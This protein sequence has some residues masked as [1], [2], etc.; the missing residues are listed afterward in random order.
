MT[1]PAETPDDRPAAAGL[2]A[3]LI[4]VA[5]HTLVFVSLAWLVRVEYAQ[6]P[7]EPE[8]SAGIALVRQADGQMEFFHGDGEQAAPDAAQP[9][10][11]LAADLP[12]RD[13]LASDIEGALPSE[14][15]L[16]GQGAG[17]SAL[18]SA[19][20]LTRGGG[21]SRQVQG[22]QAQ[23]S[24]FGAQGTGTRFLYVFDRSGSMEGYG[25]RPLRASKRELVQSLGDL[26]ETHQFQI[27]FYNE[28]PSVFTAI[29]GAKPRMA[30]GDARNKS[31]AQRFVQSIVG[32]GGTRHLD[33]L[34]VAVRLQPDVIFFLTDADEPRM[35]DRELETVRRANKGASIHAI[36][37]G[38]GP[39]RGG[40]NFLARLA[41][42]NGGQHV[43]VD[44]ARLP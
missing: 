25:G 13:D 32:S 27:I 22:K 33:A 17:D 1:E 28:R 41:R 16:L 15:D 38:H 26:G 34:L 3:W 19:G 4:S 9:T 7:G 39:Q 42:Q 31:L 44:V 5:V 29:P 14:A 43:Y 30:F 21:A 12:S 23:T 24:I 36:E 8:R 11:S 37:F 35:S 18:A 2:P 10:E 6:P 40:D 20:G